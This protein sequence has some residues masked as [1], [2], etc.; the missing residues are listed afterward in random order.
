MID[1]GTEEKDQVLV[2]EAFKKE[3]NPLKAAKWLGER[4]SKLYG[5]IF[6]GGVTVTP[7]VVD[8]SYILKSTDGHIRV[9]DD[10]DSIANVLRTMI[11]DS[12]AKKKLK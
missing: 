3:K 10:V 9:A 12:A 7:S 5:P 4:L 11:E 8:G 6:G 1:F 2:E